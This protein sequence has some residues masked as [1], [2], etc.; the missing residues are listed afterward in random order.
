MDPGSEDVIVHSSDTLDTEL[1]ALRR[2]VLHL[3]TENA[4]L[5]RLLELTPQEAR[6]PDPAQTAIFDVDPGPIHAGSSRGR[7]RQ[8]ALGARR[9]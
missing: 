2:Q 3:R 6:L 7:A 9:S 1:Q 5:L 8:Q 4:R